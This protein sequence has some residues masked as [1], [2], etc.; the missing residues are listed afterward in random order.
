MGEQFRRAHLLQAVEILLRSGTQ[1]ILP[2]AAS[3]LAPGQQVQ[4]LKGSLKGRFMLKT[5]KS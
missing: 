1:S 3:G 2:H 5:Q 4:A